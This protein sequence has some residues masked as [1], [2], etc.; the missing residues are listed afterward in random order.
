MK[1]FPQFSEHIYDY[2]LEFFI[3]KIDNLHFICPLSGV[4]SFLLFGT[5]SPPSSFC[6]GFY[7][8]FFAFDRLILPPG[9]E[10]NDTIAFFIPDLCAYEFCIK[11]I[12]LWQTCN[13]VAS[14]Y[15]GCGAKSLPLHRSLLKKHPLIM[16]V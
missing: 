13:T 12:L 2:F 4:L 3:K 7:V 8:F 10:N 6:L 5:F 15:T 14:H 1:S 9:L 11:R 16:Y